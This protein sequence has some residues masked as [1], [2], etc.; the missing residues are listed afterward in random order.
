MGVDKA[1]YDS[2]STY[3]GAHIGAGYLWKVM[4]RGEVDLSAKYLWTQMGSDSVRLN[5][6]DPVKFYVADSHRVR[7]GGRF[8]YAAAETVSPYGGVYYDYEFDG[9]V[10]GSTYG[11]GIDAPSLKGGTG[12]AEI[13]LSI[14]PSQSKPLFV[15]IGIQGYVGTREGVTGTAQLRYQF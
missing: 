6:G 14:Q 13:G 3:Y 2:K 12:I 9:K 5:T 8:T 11:F 10:K 4:D 15:D 7:V 1:S